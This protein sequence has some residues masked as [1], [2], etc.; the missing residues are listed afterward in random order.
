[1]IKMIKMTL[2]LIKML[3]KVTNFVR[4]KVKINQSVKLNKTGFKNPKTGLFILY[5]HIIT[6]KTMSTWT[7]THST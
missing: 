5:L 1:M 3:N 6:H 4:I 7:E 2:K